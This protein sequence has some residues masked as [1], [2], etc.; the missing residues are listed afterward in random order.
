MNQIK[1]HALWVG[2]AGDGAAI[3]SLYAAGIRAIVHLAAEEPP[4]Q[5][6]RD[7]IFCRF[8][9]IDGEGNDAGLLRLAV[10]SVAELIRQ[11][12][13]TLVFCGAGM[14]RSPAV[15]AAALAKI[16]KIGLDECLKQV[17][18]HHAADVSPGLWND[19][20]HAML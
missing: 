11:R 16:R 1:P 5:P 8:P 12:I 9:L 15:V 18:E 6:P 2:H 4:V 19:L 3:P 13:P 10:G 20:H 7:F 14:S 17:T